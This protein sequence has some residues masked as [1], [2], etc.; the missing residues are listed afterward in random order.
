MSVL[1]FGKCV[2]KKPG[3]WGKQETGFLFQLW[4][5][6]KTWVINPFFWVFILVYWVIFAAELVA[7]W[8]VLVLNFASWHLIN[9]A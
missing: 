4:T 3:F 7:F 5:S 1:D 9:F 8:G 2:G 6:A